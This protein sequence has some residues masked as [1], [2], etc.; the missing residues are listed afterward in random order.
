MNYDNW[1]A[2]QEFLT[3]PLL[4]VYGPNATLDGF[5]FEEVMQFFYGPFKLSKWQI[6]GTICQIIFHENYFSDISYHYQNT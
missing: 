4:S 1:P 2:G 6:K 3:Q 5:D